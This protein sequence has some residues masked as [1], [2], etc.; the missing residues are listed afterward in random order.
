ML[1]SNSV[2]F[3]NF[4]RHVQPPIFNTAQLCTPVDS[5]NY[6]PI[7]ISGVGNKSKV[8]SSP[9]SGGSIGHHLHHVVMK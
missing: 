1:C 9:F 8:A 2:K 4:K 3:L 5:E 6:D 7:K